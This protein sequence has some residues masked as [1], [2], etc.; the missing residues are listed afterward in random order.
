MTPSYTTL[1]SISKNSYSCNLA[2]VA[3]VSPAGASFLSELFAGACREA[4]RLRCSR[5]QLEAFVGALANAVTAD[6]SNWPRSATASF[7]AFR[8]DVLLHTVERSPHSS[9]ILN[10]VQATGAVDYALRSYYQNHAL[11][12]AVCARE[13]LLDLLQRSASGVIAPPAPPPLASAMHLL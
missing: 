2:G 8:E 1:P 9:S 5:V 4:F 11:Y 10:P 6:M 7:A 3:D 13:P 12:K